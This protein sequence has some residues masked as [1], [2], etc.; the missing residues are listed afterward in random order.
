MVLVGTLL[1]EVICQLMQSACT[2]PMYAAHLFGV[3]PFIVPGLW[4]GLLD[5]KGCKVGAEAVVQPDML[6]LL[7][8]M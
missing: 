6:L 4:S 5:R 3:S 7:L 8:L 2:V 1:V